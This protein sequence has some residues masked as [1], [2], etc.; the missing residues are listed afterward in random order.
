MGGSV[1]DGERTEKSGIYLSEAINDVDFSIE[2]EL[3]P[4]NLMTSE[5]IIS[6]T[7]FVLQ[8]TVTSSPSTKRT[9]KKSIQFWL[10]VR[11][12]GNFIIENISKNDTYENSS[13]RP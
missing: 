6:I 2:S 1:D 11:E 7:N 8:G 5:G 9:I 10:D 3:I 4:E 12:T 13:N